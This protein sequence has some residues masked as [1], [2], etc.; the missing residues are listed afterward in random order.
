[1]LEVE[2]VLG[3]KEVIMG[4]ALKW[5]DGIL[6]AVSVFASL[7]IFSVLT[8]FAHAYLVESFPRNGAQLSASPVEVSALFTQEL[9]SSSSTLQVFDA[10]GFQ[11]DN[12]NGGVDLFDP[13]HQSMK[14]TVPDDL[15]AGTYIV[16]WVVLSADDNDITE[17]AFVFGIGTDE[18]IPVSAEKPEKSFLGW[19]V[20]GSIAALIVILLTSML[21]LTRQPTVKLESSMN[22]KMR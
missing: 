17:G 3:F 10:D 20:S 14:V 19:W 9:V 4:I 22:V 5:F 12:G 21:L 2:M 18:L 11:V 1:V 15:G 16:E 8:T 6:V 13:A 7:F